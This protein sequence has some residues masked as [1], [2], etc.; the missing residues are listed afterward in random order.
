MF[1]IIYGFTTMYQSHSDLKC[2]GA[3][4]LNATLV[5][6]NMFQPSLILMR[7]CME[8]KNTLS[9]SK[10]LFHASYKKHTKWKFLVLLTVAD[11]YIQKVLLVK[12][13]LLLVLWILTGI[14][15]KLEQKLYNTTDAE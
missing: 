8:K 10:A 12:G 13:C 7:V 1:N 6:T 2:S 14:C 11:E 5:S 3:T 15:I 4:N 9:D